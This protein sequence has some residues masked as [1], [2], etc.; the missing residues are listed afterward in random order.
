MANDIK[1]GVNFTPHELQKLIRIGRYYV[2]VKNFPKLL[3]SNGKTLMKA[4]VIK[5]L[6]DEKLFEIR[7]IN[8][9]SYINAHKRKSQSNLLELLESKSEDDNEAMLKKNLDDRKKFKIEG[10]K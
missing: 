1:V 6:I 5:R 2:Y 4:S 9:Q 10:K 8:I 3:H 7:D